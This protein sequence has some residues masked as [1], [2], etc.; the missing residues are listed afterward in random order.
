MQQ[1]PGTSIKCIFVSDGMSVRN[2]HDDVN[3]FLYFF[4][5]GE[6]Y[7]FAK[8]KNETMIIKNEDGTQSN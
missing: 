8:G 4:V 5:R 6:I 7:P 3:D 1:F 2:Q